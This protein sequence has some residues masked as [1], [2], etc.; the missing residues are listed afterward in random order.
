MFKIFF[1]LD[2][3]NYLSFIYIQDMLYK[4]KAKKKS[5]LIFQ[6]NYK[7]FSFIILIKFPYIVLPSSE[8]P[9]DDVEYNER[10]WWRS[11]GEMTSAFKQA[12]NQGAPFPI[13]SLAE[14]F[15]LHQEGFSWGSKYR[16][17]G[18]Y[19]SLMLWYVSTKYH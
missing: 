16:Q 17:A 1:F 18:Y 19:A 4:K 8:N 15:S 11:T 14:Y 10:F 9:M 2:Y 7:L 12:L 6:L 5:S 13:V 3:I